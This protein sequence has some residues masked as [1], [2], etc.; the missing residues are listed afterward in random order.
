MLFTGSFLMPD[1]GRERRPPA[2]AT[3]L[4]QLSS[5]VVSDWLPDNLRA[6]AQGEGGARTPVTGVWRVQLKHSA[7]MEGGARSS[8]LANGWGG[9]VETG[10]ADGSAIQIQS[11]PGTCNFME[12]ENFELYLFRITFILILFVGLYYFLVSYRRKCY[13][14]FKFYLVL[15]YSNICIFFSRQNEQHIAY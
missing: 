1:L 13:V 10:D 14:F 5:Q 9:Q 2:A 4:L 3:P 11:R 6:A 8:N 12:M 7:A 15:Y